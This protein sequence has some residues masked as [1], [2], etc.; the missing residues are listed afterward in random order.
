MRMST[1]VV[2]LL[3]LLALPGFDAAAADADLIRTI[4]S[5][6]EQGCEVH[7]GVKPPLRPDPLLDRA[8]QVQ[9]SGRSLKQAMK[10]A[11]YYAVQAAVLE[12][13]GSES[14]VIRSLVD[15]G[16]KDI[17]NPIY[18]ELGIARR[19]DSVWIVL[20]APLVPPAADEAQGVSARVL[21][22][23]NE[24][25]SRSR[26]C[27]WKRFAAA[28]ALMRSE[29]LERAALAHARDMAGRSSLGHAGSDG[30]APAER[31]SRAGY[32]WRVV[33]ENIASG[34]A[35]PEQVVKEWVKSP[36]HCAN[37]MDADFT[38]MGV[39]FATD[40][41]SAGGIYWAQVFA[42]PRAAN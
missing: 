9:A 39:A 38:E 6:R 5:I 31:A 1:P 23:V 24:A 4:N 33:G 40:P 36:D 3:L 11:G 20:A 17:T 14:A 8:A 28:P 12:I 19:G 26:R 41:K 22:L 10:E 16:C 30:S 42:A 32:R 27:G 25:R 13:S 35:T 37:L 21:E 18:R 29:S 7:M 15:E 34:Q 2:T